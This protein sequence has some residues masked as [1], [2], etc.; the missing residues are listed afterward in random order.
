LFK[1]H[2]ERAVR[3]LAQYWEDDDAYF[4]NARL[5][6]EAFEQMFASDRATAETAAGKK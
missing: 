4:K 5:H 2:D 6:I 1:E 3:E